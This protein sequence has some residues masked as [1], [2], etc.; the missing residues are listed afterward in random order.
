MATITL[1]SIAQPD[2]FIDCYAIS[3]DAMAGKT[4]EEI[5]DLDVWEGKIKS[6]LGDFFDVVGAGGSTPA[7]TEIVIEGDTSRAKYIGYKMSAGSVTVKG[8]A[9]MYLGG[10]M[11]G[12]FI[13]VL[14]CR[15]VLRNP[16]GR[17]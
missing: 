4:S 17:R 10:W 16:D 14:G 15:F 7:E 9:D 6:R 11:K 1:R 3:P 8:N 2:L 12:G 5:A 13:H